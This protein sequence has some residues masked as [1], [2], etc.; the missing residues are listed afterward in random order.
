M[1]RWLLPLL[2]GLVMAVVGYQVT[3]WQY[4]RALMTLAT[5]RI[6]G[7]SFFGGSVPAIV[8]GGSPGGPRVNTMTPTE[9]ATDK[10]RMIVRPSPDLAYSACPFDLSKGPVVVTVAP[11]PA[12]Y[13][14]LS[15]FDSWTDVAFVR[16][17]IQAGNQPIKIAIAKTGQP[18][19]DGV[20]AVRVG[21]DSGIALIRILI[22]DRAQF[23]AV[24]TARRQ[25]SCKP[26]G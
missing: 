3:A 16:N 22:P 12:P 11:V 23:A 18:V 20:T 26:L 13:W 14:S 15:V 25:S 5:G 10:A 4:P 8:F 1:R 21:G 7:A 17:N 2:A 9:L 19:P 6:A 24:D